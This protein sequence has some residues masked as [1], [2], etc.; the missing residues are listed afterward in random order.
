MEIIAQTKSVRIS[1]RKVRLIT[2]AVRKLSVAQALEALGVV[3]KRGSL[4]IEKTLRSALANALN[5]KNLSEDALFIKAIDVTEGPSLKRFHASTRGRVHPFK[6]KSSHIRIVLAEKPA[7]S[8]SKAL[9]SKEEKKAEVKTK[10]NE[11]KE[12]VK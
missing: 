11:K 12:E 6:K 3:K 4:V 7:K 5:N 8:E 2:D 10:K 9:I 1:P